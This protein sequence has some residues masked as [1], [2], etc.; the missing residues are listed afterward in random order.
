MPSAVFRE[1]QEIA[2]MAPLTSAQVACFLAYAVSLL[3]MLVCEA[4]AF[5]TSQ[6]QRDDVE[7]SEKESLR[8]GTSQKNG[9]VGEPAPRSFLGEFWSAGLWKCLQLQP[10]A[11]LENR[12]YI[13]AAAEFGTLIAWFFIADRTSML[14]VGCK[15]YTRDT[16]FFIYGLLVVYSFSTWKRE[17]KTPVLL[18]RSQTEEWKGWMQVGAPPGRGGR[19]CLVAMRAATVHG[20]VADRGT[21]VLCLVPCAGTVLALPLL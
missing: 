3:L 16:F 13:H 19:N 17:W 2:G 5:F 8:K 10:A 7:K 9:D 11:L 14:P 12:Q 15:S 6:P 4:Y 21:A 20:R 18:N 1:L